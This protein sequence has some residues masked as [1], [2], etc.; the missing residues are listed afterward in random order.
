M[1]GLFGSTKAAEAPAVTPV[2]PMPDSTSPAVTEAA[3]NE[4][5]KMMSRAGRTSTILTTKDNRGSNKYDSF[6]APK[7]GVGTGG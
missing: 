1:G 5:L 6:A 4:S 3:R 7:L 2:A